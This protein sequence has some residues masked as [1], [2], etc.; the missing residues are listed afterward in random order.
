MSAFNFINSINNHEKLNINSDYSPFLT[1]RFFSY[2]IDTIH[3]A[4][5]SNHINLIE[6]NELHYNYLYNVVRKNKRFTKWFKSE[7][8]VD[9]ENISIYYDCSLNKA[10]EYK[11]LL[12]EDQIKKISEWNLRK[13]E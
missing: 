12:N 3:Y 8:D 13:G 7:K 11:D 5:E 4:N 10:K 6:N 1:T 2:F 9:L